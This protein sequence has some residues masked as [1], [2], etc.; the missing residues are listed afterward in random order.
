[1]LIPSIDLMGGNIVQLIQGEKKELEFDDF[2]PWVERFSRFPLV[3]L[4]DL[5][6]ALGQGDNRSQVEQLCRQLPCQ[7]GGGVRTVEGAQELLAAGA[8][9]VIVGSA[10]FQNGGINTQFAD[11][12]ERAVGRE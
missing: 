11:E 2:S 4:I 1:M 3:Q 6:A 9:R 10:L 12:A 7:V 8:R 5:D